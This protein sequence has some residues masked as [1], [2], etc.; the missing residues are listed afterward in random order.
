M[1]NEQKRKQKS[2]IACIALW[3]AKRR[4]QC[5]RMAQE[6]ISHQK[7]IEELDRALLRQFK[8]FI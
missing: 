8:A 6:E 1:K 2:D 3:R 7:A 5:K 4:E